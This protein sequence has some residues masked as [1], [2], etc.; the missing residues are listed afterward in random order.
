MSIKE[1]LLRLIQVPKT[2][3][4]QHRAKG[5]GIRVIKGVWF[6]TFSPMFPVPRQVRVR[7]GLHRRVGWLNMAYIPSDKALRRRMRRRGT[8]TLALTNRGAA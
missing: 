3:P 8:T 6:G 1:K 2:D 5:A 7:G 4:H